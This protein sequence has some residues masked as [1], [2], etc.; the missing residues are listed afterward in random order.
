MLLKNFDDMVKAAK[1]IGKTK[2]CAVVAAESIRTLEPVFAAYKDGFIEPILIGDAG[3][4]HEKVEELSEKT[5][6]ITIIQ[7]DTP[8]QKAQKAVDLVN[9][10]KADCFMKGNIETAKVMSVV[11]RRSS[12]MRT[13]KIVS[14]MALLDIPSYHKI[15]GYTDGGITLFPD[16]QEKKLLIE[17]AVDFLRKLGV[18]CPKVAVLTAVETVNKKIPSTVDARALREMNERG[19]IRDCIVEGPISYD[20]AISKDAAMAKGFDSPVAGDADLLLWP[21]VDSGNIAGK[22]LIHSAK[23][24]IAAL[25]LGTKVP[26]LISSRSSSYDEKYISLALMALR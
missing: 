18:D 1:K 6:G 15:I 25:I 10:G 3:V 12:K 7:A 8:E 24:R 11:L 23:A 26:I 2:R 19:E 4:I 21:D 9:E 20:L 22:A 13:G 14:G 17:N 16:L 5:S